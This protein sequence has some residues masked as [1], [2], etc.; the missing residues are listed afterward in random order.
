MKGALMAFENKRWIGW[1]VAGVVVA[2]LLAWTL[3]PR[4]ELVDIVTATRDSLAVTLDEEGETRVRERFIVSAPVAGRLLRIELEPGDAVVADETVLATF[5]PRDSTLLDVRSRAEA[6]QEVRALEAELERAK[7]ERAK[8]EAELGFAK[9][10]CSRA[11][12]LADKGVAS[13]EQLDEAELGE[14]RAVEQVSAAEHAVESATHRLAQARAHLLNI[15]DPHRK[16]DDPISIRAPV[17]GVVL[18]RKRESEAVVAA[19]E[20]ILE[21]GDPQDLEIVADYLSRDVVRI[22]PGARAL[23]ERWGGEQTLEAEVR[24]VEPSGFTKVSALGVEEQRVNVILDL[25]TP[26][27]Q[28]T[29]LKDGFRVETRIVVGECDDV[30]TVPTGSLFRRGEGWAVFVV[31]D[32]KAVVRDVEVGARTAE[33]AEMRSGVEEGERVVAHPGDRIGDGVRVAERTIPY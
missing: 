15:G 10:D 18:T 22:R 30:V 7:H 5:Q 21:V 33:R 12:R 25:V 20:Q 29:G 19:G 1:T 32:G 31:E 2:A 9:R 6:E 4:P 14:L 28:R 17:D 3:W 24:R 8:A 11:R 26:A 23:I 13:E 27:E 16:G